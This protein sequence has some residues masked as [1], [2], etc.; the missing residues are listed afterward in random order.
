MFLPEFPIDKKYREHYRV[1]QAIHSPR[2]S[3]VAPKLMHKY[4][5]FLIKIKQSLFIKGK[6]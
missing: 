3:A 6:W 1:F 4:L 2:L 5:Y